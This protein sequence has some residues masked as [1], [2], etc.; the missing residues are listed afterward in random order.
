MKKVCYKVYLYPKNLIENVTKLYEKILENYWGSKEEKLIY[1][2][3]CAAKIAKKS[4]EFY[5]DVKKWIEE[6]LSKSKREELLKTLEYYVNNYDKIVDWSLKYALED[7]LND[8]KF[9]ESERIK[10]VRIVSESG[11]VIKT[12][13]CYKVE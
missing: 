11:I 3:Y 12:K 5:N 1:V 8:P 9:A 2:L 13:K 7:L 6:I 10:L 4:D